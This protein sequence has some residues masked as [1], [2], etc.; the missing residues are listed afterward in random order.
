M[1]NGS[2]RWRRCGRLEAIGTNGE[3][4][5]CDRRGVCARERNRAMMGEHTSR[6][7]GSGLGDRGVAPLD[8]IQ[9]I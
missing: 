4:G 8:L 3:R 5:D 1:G 9:L 6:K 2:L 7:V